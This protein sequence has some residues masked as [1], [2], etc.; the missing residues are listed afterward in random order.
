VKACDERDCWG[1]PGAFWSPV[2]LSSLCPKV[3]QNQ[4][5]ISCP[6]HSVLPGLASGI[7][8]LYWGVR[9]TI[10]KE[11]RYEYEWASGSLRGSS[12][13]AVGVGSTL[14]GLVLAIWW[15]HALT[16]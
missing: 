15:V 5:R 3:V 13:V 12:A 14:M 16:D 7:P 11:T 2:H 1:Y 6:I 4:A 8:M 9:I 10:G